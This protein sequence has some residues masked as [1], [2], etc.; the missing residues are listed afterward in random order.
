MGIQT[1]KF[2][3][4]LGTTKANVDWVCFS[5]ND[6]HG[7][8]EPRNLHGSTPFAKAKVDWVRFLLLYHTNPPPLPLG[9]R[10]ST[11]IERFTPFFLQKNWVKTT[12]SENSAGTTKT[13]VEWVCFSIYITQM[14]ETPYAM[15]IEFCCK[16]CRLLI[17]AK[18]AKWALY[19]ITFVKKISNNV[20]TQLGLGG[21]DW[22]GAKKSL[23]CASAQNKS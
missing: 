9:N 6:H 13:N 21:M 1:T 17:C 14:L 10:G 15:K 23:I 12:K 18:F 5:I 20:I 7:W 4:S 19:W 11:K 2:E 3:T 8:R 16:L 22:I